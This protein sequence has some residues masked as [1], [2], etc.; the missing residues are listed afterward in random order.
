MALL[1]RVRRRIPS[2][3]YAERLRE[4][5]WHCSFRKIFTARGITVCITGWKQTDFTIHILT[6]S[7]LNTISPFLP[8]TFTLSPIR[9]LKC[10][11]CTIIHM[12]AHRKFFL[13]F[14]KLW[15]GASSSQTSISLISQRQEFVS[16]WWSVPNECFLKLTF[17]SHIG[18]GSSN[19][20]FY[21][22][23]NRLYQRSM[24]SPHLHIKI[25]FK[26]VHFW[27]WMSSE[28]I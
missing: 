20:L 6:P 3:N 9:A 24:K 19:S 14:G 4:Y 17:I 13:Q 11:E 2:Y 21:F 1:K 27:L 23:L 7:H 28:I 18:K 5:L 15:H 22:I 26:K 12:D 10:S 16:K 8:S 25:G